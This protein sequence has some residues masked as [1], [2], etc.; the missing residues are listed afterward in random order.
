[1]SFDSKFVNDWTSRKDKGSSFYVPSSTQSN[2]STDL[3]NFRRLLG[4]S[5]NE[6]SKEPTYDSQQETLKNAYAAKS[7]KPTDTSSM[8][9]YDLDDLENDEVFQDVAARFLKS[10]DED[11]DIFEY[12]RYSGY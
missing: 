5:P 1:M 6:E 3:V 8:S 12:L 9:Q 10:M 4:S 7:V 2:V 11:D